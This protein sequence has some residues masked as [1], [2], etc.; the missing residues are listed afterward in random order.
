MPKNLTAS[1]I[2]HPPDLSVMDFALSK[3][4]PWAWLFYKQFS[5]FSRKQILGSCPAFR[6][7]YIKDIESA[8]KG[9]KINFLAIM[10][11]MLPEHFLLKTNANVAQRILK[12]VKKAEAGKADVVSLGAFTSIY[13]NQGRDLARRVSPIITSGNTY[14]A[15]LCVKSIIAVCKKLEMDCKKSKLAII[16]ATGDIGGICAQALAKRF[17]KVTLCSRRL[18]EGDPIVNKIKAQTKSE[19]TIAQDAKSA[20]RNADIVISAVS[21]ISPIFSAVDFKP[22][23]VLCDISVPPAFSRDLLK[24]RRDVFAFAGGRAKIS[25]YDKILSNK[26]KTLFPQNSI[27]GCLVESLLLAFEGKTSLGGAHTEIDDQEIDRIYNL[28]LRHGCEY[29][30]FNCFDYVYNE[31]DFNRIIKIRSK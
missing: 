8:T 13:T 29:A 18:V 11:P 9:I 4:Y 16:G 1:M 7:F 15:V 20:V 30:D 3:F 24:E 22:G 25:S 27:Y 28:G 14:T 31:Q 21:S 23:A 26:W 10:L 5:L 2:F 19:V 12:A 17:Q 6:Y